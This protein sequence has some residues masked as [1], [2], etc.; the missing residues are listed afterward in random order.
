MVENQTARP[1]GALLAGGASRRMG[2]PKALLPFGDAPMI[3][4]PARALDAVVDEWCVFGGDPAE[5][6]FLDRPV[7]PDEAGPNGPLEGL[8]A[9]LRHFRER[10]VLVLAC[11]LPFVGASEL[12]TVLARARQGAVDAVVAT[13]GARWQPLCAW[14]APGCRTRLEAALAAGRR[15]VVDFARTLDGVTVDLSGGEAPGRLANVNS[16]ADYARALAWIGEG[17]RAAAAGG[18]DR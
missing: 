4:R 13:D 12:R 1:G 2:Q 16:P 18:D 14:Y 17:P 3:A 8:L 11:D 9:A 7:I 6:A 10:P 5:L 15:G